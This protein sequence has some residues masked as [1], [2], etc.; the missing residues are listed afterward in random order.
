[1]SNKYGIPKQDEKVIRARDKSCVYC[2][3]KLVDPKLGGPRRDWATTEHLNHLQDWDSV[4]SFV[5]EDKSVSTII[6]MC[7]PS[8]NS[9]R[10]A[11][12]LRDW[13]KSEYCLKRNISEKT[14]AKPVQD[15]IGLYENPLF[16]LSWKF[17][18]TMSE[19]PHYYIVRDNLSEKDKKRFDDF[20][21]YIKEKGYSDTFDSKEY[22]YLKLGNYKYWVIDNIL[23]RAQ[24]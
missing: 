20:T 12:S 1:M 24:F 23:N 22:T 19:I 10:G 7:C 6:A 15:Y 2:H 14:V 3:K 9:S 16:L 11:K 5:H 17:A 18:K 21:K 13:F 8:C 4:K